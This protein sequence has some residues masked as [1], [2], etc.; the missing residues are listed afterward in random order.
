LGRQFGSKEDAA[1][2][3]TFSSIII[4]SFA[5]LCLA[6]MAASICT[7]PREIFFITIGLGIIS[8]YVSNWSYLTLPDAPGAG[9]FMIGLYFYWKAFSVLSKRELNI[10]LASFFLSWAV[11]LRPFIIVLAAAMILIYILKIR[12]SIKAYARLAIIAMLPLVIFAGPWL[13]RN[14]STQGKVI[15]FQQD[16][17]AGY[18]Y[19]PTE[20]ASRRLMTAM[21]E[22]GGTFWDPSAMASYFAP[23]HY[24]SSTFHYAYHLRNDSS[25][26]KEIEALRAAYISSFYTRSADDEKAMVYQ[27]RQIRLQYISRHKLYYYLVNPFRRVTRFWGHSGSYYISTENSSQPYLVRLIKY[28]QSALYYFVL[29]FGTIGLINLSRKNGIGWILLLPLII[30]T[31]FFPVLNGFMEP[32]YALAFYYPGLLGLVYLFDSICKRQVTPLKMAAV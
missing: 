4:D 5:V 16:I 31:L 27:M 13:F 6:L 28:L 32:R 10:F 20:L 18:G 29:V 12:M 3:L 25:L 17:Y 24:K 15:P 30:L 2:L 1:D 9:L 21:G 7:M 11:M 19:K 14:Y 22:D 8:T 23:A 26:I